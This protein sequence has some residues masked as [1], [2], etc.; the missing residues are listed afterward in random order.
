MWQTDND[1]I[2][3]AFCSSSQNFKQTKKLIK[4]ANFLHKTEATE[5][6]NKICSSNISVIVSKSCTSF[7]VEYL[8]EINVPVPANVY[9]CYWH[10]NKRPTKM[11]W[12]ILA[13]FSDK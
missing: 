9:L 2:I 10:T 7:L 12:Y 3:F 1:S 4:T 13:W 8:F 11:K 5:T 6:K